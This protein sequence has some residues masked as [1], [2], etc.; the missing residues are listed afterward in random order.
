MKLTIDEVAQY[1]DLPA[2]TLK[3]WVR[4][5]RIPIQ[6]SG[7]GYVFK[8]SVLEKWAESHNLLFSDS[9]KNSVSAAQ[10]EQENLLPVMRRGDIFYDLAGHDTE[11]VLQS[12]VDRMDH[13]TEAERTELCLHLLDRERLTSTGIGKGIAIPHPRTPMPEI[14]GRPL[15]FTCF[16]E[17]P[18]AFNAV[19]RK[20]VFVLFILL[21][22]SSRCHLHLLSRLSF[23]LRE[24]SFVQFLRTKPQAEEIYARIADAEARLDQKESF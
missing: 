5:G 19:D 10:P 3:R 9:E 23:C 17:H 22:P 20:A 15:I 16:P 7:D 2:G 1:L 8:K 12:A 11:T 6:K 21:S 24:D 4:Q 14:I 18:V 13:L